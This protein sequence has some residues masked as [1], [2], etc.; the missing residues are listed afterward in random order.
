MGDKQSK[1]F[2]GNIYPATYEMLSKQD[3][4][5]AH[6][7]EPMIVKA[8]NHQS[9]DGPYVCGL[10]AVRCCLL[11]KN[12]KSLPGKDD[13]PYQWFFNESNE[14]L[15]TGPNPV[16]FAE[17][18]KQ[19]C[20]E[21]SYFIQHD[22]WA[23]IETFIENNLRQGHPVIALGSEAFEAHYFPI[24]GWGKH[25]VFVLTPDGQL[26]WAHKTY[27]KDVFMNVCIITIAG[28]SVFS[29]K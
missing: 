23:D 9:I 3:E 17:W 10:N 4:C 16:R 18:M 12:C 6:L 29:I 25:R 13:F 11:M 14:N 27:I 22:L 21:S 8:S 7:L 2:Y 24:V 5:S 19:W 15:R 1:G 28:Y 20:S 26:F